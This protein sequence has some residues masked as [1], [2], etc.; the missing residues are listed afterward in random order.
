MRNAQNLEKIEI[1]E[2][3]DDNV[4][5]C[6][7]CDYSSFYVFDL[8]R[9]CSITGTRIENIYERN[10]D[11]PY[12]DPKYGRKPR[13]I[14]IIERKLTLTSDCELPPAPIKQEVTHIHITP[15]NVENSNGYSCYIAPNGDIF[16]TTPFTVMSML[17]PGN[18]E[19]FTHDEF[20]YEY[21]HQNNL[22]QDYSEKQ[23][24]TQD[25]EDYY[26]RIVNEKDYLLL[27][28]NFVSVSLGGIMD[29][30]IIREP[31]NRKLTNAQHNTL[32]RYCEINENLNAYNNFVEQELALSNM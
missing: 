5:E 19:Y 10:W 4:D 20:A 13:E 9:C 11:C 17:N 6:A 18:S 27:T 14:Q 28:L 29:L 15:N 2:L 24:E 7:Y 3:I 32:K 22:H 1:I 12:D 30:T 26:L 25:L 16:L 8:S 31:N 21:I 23:T